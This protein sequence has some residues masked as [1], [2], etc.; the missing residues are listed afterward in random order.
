MARPRTVDPDVVVQRVRD[1]EFSSEVS[2]DLKISRARVNQI[3]A[4]NAPELLPRKGKPLKTSPEARAARAAQRA[5]AK[6]KPTEPKESAKRKK[7]A[8]AA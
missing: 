3:L 4:E 7:V 8:P 2:R 1:G 5:K 6:L